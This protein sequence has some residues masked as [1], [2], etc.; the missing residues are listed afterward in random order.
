ML[1]LFCE[2]KQIGRQKSH[3][4]KK[5]FDIPFGGPLVPW[6]VNAR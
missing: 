4:I 5:S 2:T 6:G 3:C 1:L